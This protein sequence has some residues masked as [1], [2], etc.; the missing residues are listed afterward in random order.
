MMP[1]VAQSD[2]AARPGLPWLTLLGAIVLVGMHAWSIATQS[3]LGWAL[4]AGRAEQL[5]RGLTA[6]WVHTDASHL[7]WNLA[8][9]TMVGAVVE[10]TSRRLL[11]AALIVGMF[12]VI[13][14]FFVFADTPYYV[15]LSGA[16]NALLVVALAS[17]AQRA[18][19]VQDRLL[20]G[21][22]VLVA[23]GYLAKLVFEAT[24][25]VRLVSVGVWDSAPG[26]HLAGAVAGCI[27]V[28]GRYLRA[29]RT[30]PNV[31]RAAT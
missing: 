27:V 28:S 17:V 4:D 13:V 15:G 7:L 5:W 12:A 24:T 29:A 18:A 25:A 30:H 19:R 23:L 22:I 8:A 31:Y 3:L 2:S 9:W 26:A 16:L 10:R 6:H 14:W 1:G 21:C 11:L 20:M